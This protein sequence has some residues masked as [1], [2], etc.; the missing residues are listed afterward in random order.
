M[1]LQELRDK[2]EQKTGIK[3]VSDK[4]LILEVL[5]FQALMCEAAY[6]NP[7][8]QTLLGRSEQMIELLKQEAIYLCPHVFT[9]DPSIILS[10]LFHEVVHATGRSNRLNRKSVRANGASTKDMWLE[11]LIAESTARELMNYYGLA[12]HTT[13]AHSSA[14]LNN[15][16]DRVGTSQLDPEDLEH[17]NASS[18]E[19]FKYITEQWLGSLT[20]DSNSSEIKQAA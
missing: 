15:V 12:T 8:K 20:T 2:V 10:T 1:T 7:D 4:K 18:K 3:V 11:E 5:S 6:L 16:F 13:N 19:A 9:K 17:V 14:Y